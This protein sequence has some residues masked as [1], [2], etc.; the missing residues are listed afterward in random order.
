MFYVYCK[1]PTH[2]DKIL[3]RFQK[4][5]L[6]LNQQQKSGVLQ[7]KRSHNKYSLF[8][9]KPQDG[10]KRKKADVSDSDDSD[11]EKKFNK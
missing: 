8:C 7:D 10:G 6:F 4:R 3:E 2:A 9:V 11:E 5:G 1:G